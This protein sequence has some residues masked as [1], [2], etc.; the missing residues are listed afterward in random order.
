MAEANVDK[1][2]EGLSSNSLN[3]MMSLIKD[4][5]YIEDRTDTNKE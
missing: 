1:T 5:T 2:D 3:Y 4:N